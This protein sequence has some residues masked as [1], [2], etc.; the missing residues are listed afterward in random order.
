MVLLL[1]KGEEHVIIT[2]KEGFV[3]TPGHLYN[4]STDTVQRPYNETDA[5]KTALKK[6]LSKA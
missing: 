3:A 4:E 5:A 6:R 1:G 2:N